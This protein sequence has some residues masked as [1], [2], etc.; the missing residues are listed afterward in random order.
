[1]LYRCDICGCYLDPDA[2]ISCAMCKTQRGHRVENMRH[3]NEHVRSL[4]AIEK[5]LMEEQ[6]ERDYI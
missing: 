2:E 5:K 1:M 4:E 3:E 6:Y